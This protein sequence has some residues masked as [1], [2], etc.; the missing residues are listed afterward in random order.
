MNSRHLRYII[1][2]YFYGL[3][4][5][6]E[7]HYIITGIFNGLF[8]YYIFK[9]HKISQKPKLEKL[10]NLSAVLLSFF[11]DLFFFERVF[12]TLSC[13]LL[14]KHI[15]FIRF[16]WSKNVF[17]LLSLHMLIWLVS[18]CFLNDNSQSIITTYKYPFLGYFMIHIIIKFIHDRK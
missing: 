8:L 17:F 11:I 5:L 9:L 15:G 2:V 6:C 1:L 18:G 7:F 12:L 13:L 3:I 10:L 16:N 14:Q 4:S